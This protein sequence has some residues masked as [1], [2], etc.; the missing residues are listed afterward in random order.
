[1]HQREGR[2]TMN[3]ASQAPAQPKPKLL[4]RV[5]EALRTRHYSPRTEEAYVGWIRRFIFFHGKRHPAGMGEA[6]VTQF[7]SSL[8]VNA[9][10]AASTQNQALSALLFLY[11]GVLQQPLPWLDNITPAKRPVRL[12]V[13]LAREEVQGGLAHLRGAPCL[14]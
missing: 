5:R 2:A 1:M 3:E 6:E 7:L 10:V 11:R 14:M 9:M 4:D 8:A 12:P 13:V